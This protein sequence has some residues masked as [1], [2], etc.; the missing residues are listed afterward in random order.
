MI[1][2]FVILRKKQTNKTKQYIFKDL[3]TEKLFE[4]LIM[5]LWHCCKNTLLEPLFFKLFF[6]LS[7]WHTKGNLQ[8][9]NK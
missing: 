3:F 6:S 2:M 4:E 9:K 1:K 5:V 7:L 8:V